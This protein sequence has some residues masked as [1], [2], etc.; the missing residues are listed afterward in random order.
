M[1]KTIR[2]T[3]DNIKKA[4]DKKF[5]NETIDAIVDSL[6]D[7]SNVVSKIGLHRE[8][9]M[10]EINFI[11]NVCKTGDL[12]QILIEQWLSC[13][14]QTEPKINVSIFSSEENDP[15]DIE[16]KLLTHLKS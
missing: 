9:E 14:L 12:L 11:L 15:Y 8:K 7:F 5:V 13:I 4:K 16:L 1:D 2:I 6:Y 3:I 10:F